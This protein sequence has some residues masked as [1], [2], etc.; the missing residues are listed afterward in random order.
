MTDDFFRDLTWRCDLCHKE[1]PDARI[2]VHKVDIGLPKFPA[3]IVIRNVKYCSDNPLCFEGAKNWNEEDH[4]ARE[5]V[6][7]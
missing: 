2:S 3:G 5:R 4:L 7:P 6:K 1:R